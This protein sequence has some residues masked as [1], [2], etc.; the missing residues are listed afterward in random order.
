LV[1]KLVNGRKPKDFAMV[2]I[3]QGID[4]SVLG[5]RHVADARAHPNAFL[6]RDPFPIEC[7]TNDGF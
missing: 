1:K 7:K 4:G 5:L 2:F 3:G 6:P